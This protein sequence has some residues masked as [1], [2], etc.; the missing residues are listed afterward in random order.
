ML[1]SHA[2]AVAP[3]PSRIMFCQLAMP[4]EVSSPSPASPRAARYRPL[5]RKAAPYTRGASAGRGTPKARAKALACKA[6]GSLAFRL[7]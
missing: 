2:S 1:G 4:L 6:S 3:A 7:A 5:V